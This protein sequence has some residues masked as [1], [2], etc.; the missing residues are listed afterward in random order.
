MGLGGGGVHLRVFYPYGFCPSGIYSW[1]IHP[2][3]NNPTVH[4]MGLSSL[5]CFILRRFVPGGFVSGGVSR[6]EARPLKIT[7]VS[8][9]G[10]AVIVLSRDIFNGLAEPL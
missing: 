6:G 1:R 8:V 10:A 5:G 3:G 7:P 2:R 4:P 9:N